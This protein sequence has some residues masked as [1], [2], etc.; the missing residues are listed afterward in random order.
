M[1]ASVFLTNLV[2]LAADPSQPTAEEVLARLDLTSFPNSTGPANLQ[3]PATP[4]AAG[5]SEAVSG[6][7]GWAHRTSPR[8]ELR[9]GGYRELGLRILEADG[10][11]LAVCFRDIDH[12]GGSYFVQ[13][14]L[15][16]TPT[17]DGYAAR[18]APAR[19]DCAE[20]R[21]RSDAA[22]RP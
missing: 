15:I 3:A 18:K 12:T 10:D 21:R 20:W 22:P 6:E 9:D 5:F 8:R 17:A 11:G 4:L 1:L 19:A 16:V 13:T 7:E 14:A 2:L